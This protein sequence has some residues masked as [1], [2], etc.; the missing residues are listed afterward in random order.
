MGA[1]TAALG[2]QFSAGGNLMGEKFANGAFIAR[3]G[4]W[5]RKPLVGYD[6]IFVPFDGNGNPLGKPVQVLGSFLTGKGHDTHGR[7]VWLAWDKPGA[8]LVSDDT[9]GVIWRVMAPG[10]SPSTRP[11]AVVTQRMPALRSLEGNT[12]E[13]FRPNPPQ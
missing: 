11:P 9:G 8:L 2:L 1:H 10:A 12:E 7:P 6:V 5:N 3:H 4:S 13:D